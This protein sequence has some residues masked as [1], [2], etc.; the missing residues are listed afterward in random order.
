MLFPPLEDLATTEIVSVAVSST[1][2]DALEKMARHKVRNIVIDV[3]SGQ[4]GLLTAADLVRLQ[5]ESPELDARVGEV[6]YRPL[7]CITKGK[8]ILDALDQLNGALGY[9]VIVD[10]TGKL[11]GIVSNT[12]IISSLD[13]QLMM[14]R[15]SLR[16]LLQ[17][18]EIKTVERDAPLS[19]ALSKLVEPDDAVIVLEQGSGIG[20]VTTQDAVHLLQDKVPMTDPV[21][22]HMSSPLHTVSY[23]LTVGE[24]VA[25]LSKKHFKRLIVRKG[26]A[27][28]IIGLISQ[29]DLIGV[30]YSRWVDLM[31]NH[32]MELREIVDLLERKT[33]H[34]EQLVEMDPLTGVA[35]R[36]NFERRLQEELGQHKRETDTEFSVV[37]IDIDNFKTIND[38]WGHQQGDRILR[39]V[40]S[41]ITSILRKD[42]TLARWGG[43]E[44]VLLLP[45]TNLNAAEQTATKICGRVAQ[46]QFESTGAVTV[47][48]G[49]AMHQGGESSTDLFA[50]A[51]KAL[52]RAKHNG[53]N[54][55]EISAAVKRGAGS[56]A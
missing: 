30:A 42:D 56:A 5:I 36:A 19:A 26:H 16:D 38:T 20:I 46:I 15:L 4:Y 31:R 47:S 2:K 39:D 10:E 43:D 52:Y 13:P 23:D 35:N 17:R 51:D 32:A 29:K 49:V 34:L 25:T 50:R 12:D 37:L 55:V 11:D 48:M 22:L 7:P 27:N 45:N 28:E 1:A 8:T 54:R 41:E 44:F 18:Q 21:Y 24:A 33:A 40:V 9:V 14:Q 53:R 3:G 6:R